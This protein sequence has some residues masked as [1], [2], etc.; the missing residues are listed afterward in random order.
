MKTTLPPIQGHT[1]AKH[2]ILEYHMKEWFPILGRS[3][4]KLRYIDG[5]AGPGEYESGERG[6][7]LIALNTIRWHSFF[8]DFSSEGRIA[9]FLFVEKN[10]IFYGNLKKRVEEFQKP[11]NFTVEVK[12]G[13]FQHVMSHVLDEALSS[14]ETFPPT[15]LFVDPFGPAGFPMELFEKLALFER[16]DVL[17]NL[18]ELE[19]IQ[20]ILPDSSKHITADRL[21]G[22]SRWRPAL[23]MEG[24]ER[25]KFLVDEY[26]NAL[27]E[28]GWRGTSFEMV[29]SQNQIP[30]HL[31]FGT[32]NQKGLE[33]I[34]RA[35]RRASQTGEFRYTD[36]VDS[37]QTLLPG[38]DMARQFP[39]ELGEHVFQKYEGQE[40]SFD[41][42][43]G[44]EIDWHRWW[45]P[46]DLRKGLEYLEY[47]DDERI[48]MV[49]NGDG[50]TRKP[51]SYPS[52]CMI[53]FGRPLRDK[54]GQLF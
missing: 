9:E 11:S 30:Y 35:M 51:K 44:N 32:R 37:S 13:E 23:N 38:F 27:R 40:V 4:R 28:I 7:P 34:K 54:Q 29:N 14:G 12:R 21:Y 10:E 52:G 53:T 16:V 26:E 19:F 5:F 43:I 46:T 2:H 24:Q 20:W 39:Q 50:R 3:N 31:I 33:A 47:G 22:G 1:K 36:R 48:S 17:I 45:L 6:S 49:R 42:L 18:N 41:L 25:S 15:F 8:E